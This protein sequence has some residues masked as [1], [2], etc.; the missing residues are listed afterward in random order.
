[1]LAP[2]KPKL[3][4][5]PLESVP[6]GLHHSISIAKKPKI[7]KAERNGPKG[8]VPSQTAP[9]PQQRFLATEIIGELVREKV[10][11]SA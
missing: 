3:A 1:M 5:K 6:C 9:V 8:G 10:A 2:S 11:A 7:V 4:K